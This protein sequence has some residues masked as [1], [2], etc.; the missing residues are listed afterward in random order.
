MMEM[1]IAAS[2]RRGGRPRDGDSRQ[3]AGELTSNR[4][5]AMQIIPAIDVKDGRCVRL[6][7]G[8]YRRVTVYSDQPARLARRWEDEGARLLHVVDLDGAYHGAPRNLKAIGEIIRAVEIPVQVGGGLRTIEAIATVLE[9]GAARV[10]LGTA[11]VEDRSLVAMAAARWPGRVAVA[12]DARGG[13]VMTRGWQQRSERPAK[14]VARDVVLDGAS[15]LIY[16]DIERDGTLTEPNYTATAEIVAAVPV[17]VIASGG[18]ARIEHLRRLQAVG[19]E[20]VIVG[21][22]LYT[23]AVRL[24]DALALDE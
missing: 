15:C 21:Q 12:I 24:A 14:S 4:K 1:V 5:R 20:G 23:G 11:A 7:Q 3:R 10:V 6:Y 13:I 2:A 17:P 22:A 8:D 19:V 16:T 18:V 9:L